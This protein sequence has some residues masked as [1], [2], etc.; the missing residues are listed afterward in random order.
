MFSNDRIIFK[1][2]LYGIMLSTVYRYIKQYMR[3]DSRALTPAIPLT[4]MKIV[5]AVIHR[6]FGSIEVREIH[7]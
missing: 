4:L 5:S 1:P 2:G 6:V 3:N 7:T